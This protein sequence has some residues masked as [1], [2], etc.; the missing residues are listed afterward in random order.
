MRSSHQPSL[1]AL[2]LLRNSIPL[3]MVALATSLPSYLTTTV[4]SLGGFPLSPAL[5]PCQSANHFLSARSCMPTGED[6]QCSFTLTISL[7]PSVSKSCTRASNLSDFS[8]SSLLTL[9]VGGGLCLP[10]IS[11]PPP[12]EATS[13]A[14]MNRRHIS[15]PAQI[16]E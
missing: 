13:T 4:T 11:P 5:A 15:A 2:G 12:H 6:I 16:R 1:L 8:T 10:A 3:S 7:S 14:P 9:A